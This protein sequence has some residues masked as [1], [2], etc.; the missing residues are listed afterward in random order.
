MN[1]WKESMTVDEKLEADP[2]WYYVPPYS[3]EG[4]KIVDSAGQEVAVFE[5]K[6]QAIIAVQSYNNAITKNRG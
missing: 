6:D 3:N 1:D 5:M 2:K 4:H